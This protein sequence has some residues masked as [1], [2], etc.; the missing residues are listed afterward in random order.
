M[1]MMT[2]FP[3]SHLTQ[4][5]NVKFHAEEISLKHCILNDKMFVR[6]YLALTIAQS[7]TYSQLLI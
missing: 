2:T 5:L 6:I 1:D 4:T 7:L 3:N